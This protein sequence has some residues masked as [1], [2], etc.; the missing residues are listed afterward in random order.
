MIVKKQTLYISL[1][2]ALMLLACKRDNDPLFEDPDSRL[3]EALTDYRSALLSAEH[4]WIA[5]LYPEG[6]GGYVFYF[7]F[8][9][10][11][12]VLMRSDFHSQS[13]SESLSSSYRLKA[14]QRP[15]LIFDTY[16]YLHLLSD[17]DSDVNGGTRGAGLVSDFEFAL[18]RTTEDSVYLEGTFNGNDMVLVKATAI[19]AD[20]IRNDGWNSMI[21]NTQQA[22]NGFTY[23]FI[24][25]G[26]GRE[27]SLVI[28]PNGKTITLTI[29]S[30]DGDSAES[31]VTHFSYGLDGLELQNELRYGDFAFDKLYWDDEGNAFYALIDGQRYVLQ[32]S[33]NPL[34]PLH[35]LFGHVRD[36]TVINI[37][38][39]SLIPG[40][41]SGFNTVFANVVNR[42]RTSSTNGRKVLYTRFTF[43]DAEQVTLAVRYVALDA[44][45]NNTG[46]EF[47]AT[48]TYNYTLSGRVITLAE[49]GFNNNWN[50]RANQLVPFREYF[51]GASFQI[52]WVTSMDPTVADQ[53]GGLYL[54]D[55]PSSFFYGVLQ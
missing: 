5:K 23:P 30:D 28:V 50:T 36:Y 47:S 26:D 29:L 21:A 1:L 32:N 10:D 35:T 20:G 27:L 7:D 51:D 41:T 9:D 18:L 53:L 3:I 54:E 4:G 17:P 25:F 52:A 42:F 6:G 31:Q 48:A 2:L 24:E 40:V 8:S 12:R 46:S 11:D 33:I 44:S 55:D 15:T 19:E 38:G 49:A 34:V 13:A 22:I 45:G 37:N 16:N 39:E 14:L 43:V